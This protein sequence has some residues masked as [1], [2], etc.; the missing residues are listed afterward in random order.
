[1]R[2]RLTLLLVALALLFGTIILVMSDRTLLRAVSIS[3]ARQ[4]TGLLSSAQEEIDFT[5]KASGVSGVTKVIQ[6][7]LDVRPL[8]YVY[9]K[10]EPTPIWV[11]NELQLTEKEVTEE[12]KKSALPRR[13]RPLQKELKRAGVAMTSIE[14][15]GERLV[16]FGFGTFHAGINLQTLIE[17]ET[18][19]YGW[20]LLAAFFAFAAGIGVSLFFVRRELLPL[21]QLAEDAKRV[22]EK[23]EGAIV[24]LRRDGM[25]GRTASMLRSLSME[26]HVAEQQLVDLKQMVRA[27]LAATEIVKPYLDLLFSI[28]PEGAVLIDKE[29]QVELVNDH[30]NQLLPPQGQLAKGEL[31]SRAS[32]KWINE[33]LGRSLARYCPYLSNGEGLIQGVEGAVSTL[34]LKEGDSDRLLGLLALIDE[35]TLLRKVYR[36]TAKKLDGYRRQVAAICDPLIEEWR[37]FEKLLTEYWTPKVNEIGGDCRRALFQLHD[38]IRSAIASAL[39]LN[40]LSTDF[41]KLYSIKAWEYPL[42]SHPVS[43][44]LLLD[45]VAHTLKPLFERESLRLLVHREGEAME[46]ESDHLA[47]FDLTVA[48]VLSVWLTTGHGTLSLRTVRLQRAV[49]F[50]IEGADPLLEPED[51]FFFFDPLTSAGTGVHRLLVAELAKRLGGRALVEVKGGVNLYCVRICL[52]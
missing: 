45:E 19:P 18:I 34:P 14:V 33:L 2:L 15:R 43:I 9:V 38:S 39:Y 27:R 36:I 12:S 26:R 17:K 49:E 51:R 3:S 37:R 5:S 48:L 50:V 7:T 46:I 13:L 11:S 16:D 40:Q 32:P 42:T 29:A 6:G 25:I 52:E 21:E 8:A 28:L 22:A 47:L 41:F 31:C 30:F 44:P 4:I 35:E 24:N 23:R 20:L 1:M 10:L